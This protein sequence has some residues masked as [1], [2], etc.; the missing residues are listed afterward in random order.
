[1]NEDRGEG[2]P[3]GCSVLFVDDEEDLVEKFVERMRRRG[4]RALGALSGEDAL[5]LLEAQRFDVVVIDVG[6]P[7]MGGIEVLM[8]VKALRP[9]AEVV[10]ISAAPDVDQAIRGIDLGAFDYLVKPLSAEELLHR[11]DDAYRF[12]LA[13]ADLV[14]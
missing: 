1:M 11:I 5:A 4:L 9:E 2:V 13:A 6:M 7:G 10:M 12:K 14:S 3:P 8:E